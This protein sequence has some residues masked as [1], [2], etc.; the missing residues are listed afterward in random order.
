MKTIITIMTSALL[1][2][3]C[4]G[5]E[6]ETPADDTP[7][8]ASGPS[9][10]EPSVP[11]TPDPTSP[12]ELVDTDSDGIPDIEDNDIDGDGVLNSLDAFALDATESLDT[13]NDGIGNNADLDDDSDGFTDDIEITIGSDP[14]D[15]QSKPSDRDLDGIPDA[16]DGDIDGD[17]VL[18]D[19]D[20]FPFDSTEQIDSDLDGLGNNSDLDDDND[21]Y[22]DLVEIS[23][24]TDPLNDTSFPHDLDNDGTPDSLDDDIDGDGVLNIN[25]D[26]P[27]DPTD[28]IDTDSDGVGNST[29]TDDDDDGYSDSDEDTAGSDPLDALS[30]PDDLDNDGIPDVLDNDIDGDEVLNDDDAF[31]FD[32]TEQI[33]SDLDGLGNNSDLDDDNDGYSDSDEITAGSDPLDALSLPDDLDN[34]GIPDVL[35]ADIDGDDVDNNSDAFPE[36]SN[37]Q[38]DTD[39]DGTGNNS[40]TDDDGDG[41]SDSDEDTAG[42]DPL[43]ALS[44]PDDLDNDGTPDVLDTDIDGDGYLNAEDSHPY[45]A[46][47]PVDDNAGE[48]SELDQELLTLLSNIGFN[49]AELTGRELPV[50]GDPLVE[51]GKELFFSRS[52]SFGDDVACASCHD[53]R[54]AGTDNLSLSVGVGAH[55]PMIVGP[56]RRHDGNFYLDPEADFGPNVPRN[57]PTTFNIAFYDKAMFWDGRVETVEYSTS[58]GYY[59]PVLT[60]FENGSGAQIR[61]PDS[62]F[63]GPDPLAG[64][65]LT[66]A[67][68]RFPVTSVDEMRGF[69]P[70]AGATGRDIRARIAN[71]LIDRGWEAYFR[72]AFNDYV[73]DSAELV[74]FNNITLALGEYQRSQVALDNPFFRFVEGDYT[75]ITETAKQGALLFFNQGSLSCASCHSSS[76]FSDE[77]YY[78]LATPQIGRGKNVF[79]QDLGRYNVSV[80]PNDKHQF[81]TPSLLN[82]ELTEPYMHAGSIST[83]E[84]AVRWH[85]NPVEEIINYDYTLQSLDQFLG[86]DIDTTEHQER[87]P[88]ILES[89]TTWNTNNSAKN[90]AI[91]GDVNEDNIPAYVAFIK[92]LTSDCLIDMVCVSQWMPDFTELSPDNMRLDP[93]LSYFDNSELFTITPPE[94]GEV[95]PGSFPNLDNVEPYDVSACAQADVA[96]PTELTFSGFRKSHEDDFTLEHSVGEQILTNV[97]TLGESALVIGSIGAADLN[98]DCQIDLVIGLGNE[99]GVKV[100]LNDT[101]GF[102]EAPDNFGLNTLGDIAAFSVADINGDGWTDLFVGH[103]YEPDSKLWINNGGTGFV[104]VS[105]FGVDTVRATHSSSFSDIDQ[106]GDLDMF[107]THWDFLKTSEEIHLWKNDGK[108]FFEPFEGSGLEGK[109]GSRDYTFTANFADMNA[110]GVK[111]LMIASDFRTT[112][113]YKGTIDGEYE[114]IPDNLKIL[115]F[116]SMGSALGDIDN[117]GDLDW[118]VS[119]I[120][121]SFGSYSDSGNR[122]Y[123]ND[124][125]PSGDIVLE[126]ISLESGI[127][128]GQWAWGAC[129]KDFNNDGWIDIFHVN[130]F[131]YAADDL[132]LPILQSLTLIGVNSLYDLVIFDFLTPEDIVNQLINTLGDYES[133]NEHL[134]GEYESSTQLLNKLEL[135]LESAE[136][137]FDQRGPGSEVFDNFYGTPAKLFMNN[138][139]GTF[140]EQAFMFGIDDRGE[141]RGIVCNDFDRDGDIDITIMNHS[142]VPVFYENHFRRLSDFSDN[143]LNIRLHGVGGNQNA[144]GAKV[145]VSAGD[146]TQY[147]EMRFENNYMSN[148]APELHF[149]LAAES[150]IDEIRVEWP[151]GQ[152]TLFTDIDVNQFMVIEHPSYLH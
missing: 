11:E 110:D 76:H 107:T 49:P 99:Q 95:I 127:I 112:Q 71:K 68:A 36:D 85:F 125:E 141:G 117:D 113:A 101:D 129:F 140:T 17:G 67:Q 119:D 84:E 15:A 149:G 136:L 83:L 16:L 14:L 53:P 19:D 118:F 82:A 109:F 34:D 116:S 81:R 122:L 50:P 39:S 79:S 89:L 7:I 90:Y 66:V 120:Y 88:E 123:R 70:D 78:P 8:V 96:S 86:L 64:P 104:L 58:R 87:I 106:D 77:E 74:S 114:V 57:S 124:S 21:G 103:L 33:D 20:V 6:G 4:G 55:D 100:Y 23:V 2:A 28:S 147:R 13:D 128:D 75:A 5:E 102:I 30:L 69:S 138:Q 91:N 1:L 52:L 26:L 51:L 80:N 133:V 73:S 61:T 72:E 25:D 152:V 151:D 27:L 12:E 92:T 43:D 146:L 130:G 65:N 142:D 111:D 93:V 18:N 31:P 131:G 24:G 105:N 46:S 115:G 108:G 98:G 121:V 126:N 94:P 9:V 60:E 137:L 54:L 63:G 139:D 29:D 56:G 143:F 44:L 97:R 41:Y 48:P 32:S 144:F 3:S 22:S 150:V 62:H 42:S 10:P 38:L 35:D 45:D 135:L 145:T 59:E 134:N 47:L 132:D 37:E 40:D 148:N